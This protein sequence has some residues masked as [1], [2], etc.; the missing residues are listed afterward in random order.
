MPKKMRRKAL[1]GILTKKLLDEELRGVES[2]DLSEIKTKEAYK[3]LWKLK[4]EG[5][6]VLLVYSTKWDW[7]RAFRNLPNVDFV[8][9]GNLNPHAL[10]SHKVVLFEEGALDKLA[11]VYLK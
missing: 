2:F 11:E 4:L 3:A 10:L 8:D 6:K 5:V 7:Q 9:V 1:F